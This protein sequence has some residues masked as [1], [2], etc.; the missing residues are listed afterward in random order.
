MS[1]RY[2]AI[3]AQLPHEYLVRVRPEDGPPFIRV[4]HVEPVA[5][6][7]IVEFE[8]QLGQRLPED[9][10]EFLGQYGDA[11]FGRTYFRREVGL[12]RM[13]G[14]RPI[15][16]HRLWEEWPHD[17]DMPDFFLPIGLSVID[18][19]MTISLG[20]EDYGKIYVRYAGYWDKSNGTYG[21][22]G[23]FADSFHELITGTTAEEPVDA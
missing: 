3:M 18:E 8:K 2:D 7:V 14:L 10:R 13:H 15:S 19:L 5:N 22:V 23:L 11:C 17:L 9:Y 4:K 12:S 16:A 1:N 20:R 6:D 21:G